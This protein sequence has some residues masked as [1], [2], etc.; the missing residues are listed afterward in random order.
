MVVAPGV[1][2]IAG[3]S[4][5]VVEGR[6]GWGRRIFGGIAGGGMPDVSADVQNAGRGRGRSYH[7]GGEVEGGEERGIRRIDRIGVPNGLMEVNQG[8]GVEMIGDAIPVGIGMVGIGSEL[9]FLPVGEVVCVGIGVGHSY[10]PEKLVRVGSVPVKRFGGIA[11]RNSLGVEP[12]G[13]RD[14]GSRAQV[15]RAV[16]TVDLPGNGRPGEGVLCRVQ[17]DEG[18]AGHRRSRVAERILR[19][20]LR[21]REAVGILGLVNRRDLRDGD[22]DAAVRG[23][24]IEGVGSGD[25][26]LKVR[27]PVAIGI[28]TGGVRGIG[29][30]KELV[31]VME[32]FPDVGHAVSIGID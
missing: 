17:K 31:V 15:R 13:G 32:F 27:P 19:R 6:E 7:L 22:A 8:G 10:P 20:V 26:L 11:E 30:G 5:G 3:D 18:R 24:G 9:M 1:E 2:S 29:R 23:V 4:L 14:P 16:N 28:G 12:S 21:R 25:G